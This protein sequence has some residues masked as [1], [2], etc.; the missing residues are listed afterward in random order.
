MEISPIVEIAGLNHWFGQAAARKQA[1][2]DINLTLARGSFTVLMGPSG[3]GKT[4]LLTLTGCLRAVQEGSLRLIDQE[5]KDANEAQLVLMRRKLGFIFQAH[6][7]HESLTAGQNVMMGAQVHPGVEADLA[8]RAA[9]H[10]LGLVGM[11]DRVDYLPANLSGGQKQRVAVARALVGGPAL[12]LADE[13]TAALDKDSASDVIDLVRRLGHKRGMTTLLVTHD[14]RILDRAD[15]ILTL[16][17]GRI[18]ADEVRA[19]A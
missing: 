8:T 5:L 12:L 6:N 15:R 10:L 11:A 7:L 2:F 16:E 19:S 17:D 9:R 18:V 3:S 13:P 1:L 4:T 14:N